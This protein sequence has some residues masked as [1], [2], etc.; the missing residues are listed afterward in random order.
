M[1]DRVGGDSS[2][3]RRWVSLCAG[4]HGTVSGVGFVSDV[5]ERET[6]A[7]QII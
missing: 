3:C 5:D 2:S 4:R 1:A 6:E 7:R